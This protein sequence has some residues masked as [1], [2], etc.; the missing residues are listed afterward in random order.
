MKRIQAAVV[1]IGSPLQETSFFKVIQNRHQAARVD[2]QLA[3][4]LLLAQSGGNPQHAQNA[5]VSRRQVKNSQSLSKL[6]S[7]MR[8]KL[9]KE[10]RW[11]SSFHSL[12]SH[13]KNNYCIVYSFIV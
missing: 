6:R 11:F 10:E 4:E 8:T 7:G 5:G 12:V 3:C 2:L 9:G 1:G 13:L